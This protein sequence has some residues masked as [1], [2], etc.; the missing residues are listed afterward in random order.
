MDPGEEVKTQCD[1]ELE[2]DMGTEA[3]MERAI[4]A[5]VAKQAVILTENM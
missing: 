4:N 3:V 2:E 5:A 1:K